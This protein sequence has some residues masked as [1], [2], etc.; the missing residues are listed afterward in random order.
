MSA[1]AGFREAPTAPRGEIWEVDLDPR[2]GRE[3]QGT[4]PCLIV[5][6]DALNRS[7]FGTVIV[8][9]ITTTERKQFTWRPGLTPVDLRIADARWQAKPHWVETDQIVTVDASERLQRHL[10]TVTNPE[11]MREVDVWLRRL[12][13]PAG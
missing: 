9:P 8:C 5:S 7:R 13:I 6:T 4:R 1:A 12:L 3:Q 11:K 10:A 2:K